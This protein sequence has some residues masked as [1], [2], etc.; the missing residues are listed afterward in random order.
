MDKIHYS[1]GTTD[2]QTPPEIFNPLNEEFG[3]DLDVCADKTN[4][5]CRRYFSPQK[6][7]LIQAWK[8]TCWMNPPYGAGLTR[9]WMQKAWEEKMAGTT[10]VCLIPARTDTRAWAVFYDHA[11]FKLR[12]RKDEIRFIKGRIK[13]V[14]AE[15]GAPFPSAII[16][17]RGRNGWT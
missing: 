4:K 6:N 9:I 14:G 3:F 12:D 1:T 17:L 15:H 2:W 13:F 11:K 10:V 7:A 8:G 5:K 16:V